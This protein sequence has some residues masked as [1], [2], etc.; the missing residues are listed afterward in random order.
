[1]SLSPPQKRILKRLAGPLIPIPTPLWTEIGDDTRQEIFKR[2]IASLRE[3]QNT[4]I[5]DIIEANPGLGWI[6][7][8]EKVRSMRYTQRK[9]GE[10][11]C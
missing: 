6:Y 1:M 11:P 2:L 5:A 7:L 4:G 3:T 8:Q 9:K 10:I